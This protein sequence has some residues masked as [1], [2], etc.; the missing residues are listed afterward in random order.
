[1]KKNCSLAKNVFL[2]FLFV[3]LFFGCTNLENVSENKTDDL[4]TNTLK[5]T[6]QAN[7]RYISAYNFD[8]YDF[9]NWTL[10][11]KDENNKT[12]TLSLSDSG[13]SV[14]MHV[15]SL[16]YSSGIFIAKNIP[17]GTYTI[18]IE[19]T[20][21]QSETTYT[22]TGSK[23][24]IEIVQGTTTETSLFLGLKK[25]SSGYGGL[26]LSLENADG[27]NYFSNISSAEARLTSRSGGT[28]YSTK[29]AN[30]ILFFED[31]S[32]HLSADNGKI[33]SGW[34]SLS[35]ILD[36]YNFTLSD[37]EIEIADGLITNDTIYVTATSS[38]TYYAT[39]NVA[40]GNGNS[41]SSRAN[42]TTLLEKLSE[43]LP[44]EQLIN[45]YVNDEPEIDL[46]AFSKL[47]SKL[48][49]N[50]NEYRKVTIY[51]ES[52]SEAMKIAVTHE[53]DKET[54]TVSVES[55]SNSITLIGRTVDKTDYKTVD[56][57]QIN[58]TQATFSIT[59]ID[60]VAINLTSTDSNEYLT[61]TLGINAFTADGT[62]NLSAYYDMPFITFSTNSVANKMFDIAI[63]YGISYT[64]NEDGSFDYFIT[65]VSM[66]TGTE[67]KTTLSSLIS[68]Y[69]GTSLL[70]KAYTGNSNNI[71]KSN[72]LSSDDSKTPCY[73]WLDS[74]NSTVYYYAEGY[75]D[76]DG[77]HLILLNE[78]S[79]EMFYQ[80]DKFTEIDM[81][82]FSTKNVTNMKSMF[83]G[84]SS[85][86]N[87]DVSRFDTS[88]VTDMSNMF[89]SC[90]SLTTIY[91]A[92]DADWSNVEQSEKMFDSCTS[93]EGGNGTKY[94]IDN[95]D[96]TYARIDKKENPGYFTEKNF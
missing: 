67:I 61:N 93:L 9:S 74:D 15:P 38:K 18:A 24:G 91:A 48:A 33:A 72:T 55:I 69:N 49:D 16:S 58:T 53:T 59:L 43:S 94:D 76:S 54:Y 47:K 13:D 29:D 63:G 7:V 56:V 36:G 86:E 70:F 2:L 32:Y 39:N 51:N 65:S 40:M 31:S 79:A 14:K 50:K 46:Y 22:L 21:T 90:S 20:Y 57:G 73:V 42:L 1:M 66:K 84:C 87:L 4:S 60:G 28:N 44:R 37:T 96:A 30:P 26:T 8:L 89:S 3:F 95:V 68:T 83:E 35:F 41:T 52:D 5:I 12:L 62:E 82:G 92:S 64:E 45:I 10:T 75:T 11:F 34:Y 17:T 23:T 19:G 78:N 77:T 88:K 71:E 80:N 85:L 25:S 27:S 81:S 6:L